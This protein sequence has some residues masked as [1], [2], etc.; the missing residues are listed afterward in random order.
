MKFLLDDNVSLGLAHVLRERE[1]AVMAV[2]ET[3]ERG[4]EDIDVWKL[5]QES[6]SISIARDYHSTNP[7]RFDPSTI[8]SIIYLRPGNLSSK[9]EIEL[10]L[11]FVASYSTE[12]FHGKLVT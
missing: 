9:E 10:V 8:G 7:N 6:P 12:H 2:A 1:H 4:V 3:A 11:K 5:A